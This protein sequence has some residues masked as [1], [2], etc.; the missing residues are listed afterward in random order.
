MFVEQKWLILSRQ[1]SSKDNV[2]G[3]SS[4]VDDVN[5]TPKMHS[6]IMF[7]IQ[8]LIGGLGLLLVNSRSFSHNRDDVFTGGLSDLEFVKF[9]M[10][11]VDA[12]EVFATSSGHG[13][14]RVTASGGGFVVALA[15]SEAALLP[16][17]VEPPG[18]DVVGVICVGAIDLRDGLSPLQSG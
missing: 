1:R 5:E 2:Q 14:G 4:M 8:L 11:A 17:A 7:S 6:A 3:M 12:N 15:L 9:L 10:V 13:H 16:K 18:T